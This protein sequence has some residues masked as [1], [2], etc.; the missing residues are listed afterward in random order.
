MEVLGLME[1]AMVPRTV[2]WSG[3]RRWSVIGLV[4]YPAAGFASMLALVTIERWILEPAGLRPESGTAAWGIRLAGW[5]VLWG[6]LTA[7][8]AAW[9][10]GRLVPGHRFKRSGALALLV[11][12]TLAAATMFTLHEW[13]RARFGYFDSDFVGWAFFAAPAVVAV[14]LCAW[15]ALSIP[16]G[17]RGPLLVLLILAAIGFVAALVPSIG[18]LADGLDPRSLG[19]A[20]ILLADAAFGILSMVLVR[21]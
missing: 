8:P 13:T 19:L 12:L 18:G 2:D 15:A 6:A 3:V 4:L 5:I 9:I 11:G 16:R 7:V 20:A 21:R 14:A 10:G 17:S 1:P